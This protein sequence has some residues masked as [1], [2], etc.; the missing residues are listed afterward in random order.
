MRKILVLASLEAAL[1][2]MASAAGYRSLAAN[3][4]GGFS[5]PLNPTARYVARSGTIDAGAGYNI[6]S[7]SSVIGEF[8]WAGEPPAGSSPQ[9]ANGPFGRVNLFTITANYRYQHN[10]IGRSHIG[11]YAIGGGGWYYRYTSVNANYAVAPNTVCQSVFS[12]WGFACDPN[13]FVSANAVTYKFTSTGGVNAGIGFTFPLGEA[14]WKFYAE[15]RYHYA[16]SKIPSSLVLVTFG[17]R[18]N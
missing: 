18:F 8:M 6:D 1:L 3:I 16:F 11:V 4:G 10:R 2:G 15:T 17:F 5:N 12:W 7:R 9:T 14:R 13:G